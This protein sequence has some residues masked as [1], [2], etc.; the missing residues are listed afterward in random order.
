MTQ[1][2]TAKI[3]NHEKNHNLSNRK[4]FVNLIN[5]SSKNQIE[6]QIMIK[7]LIK[8]I[9]KTQICSLLLKKFGIF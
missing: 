9:N 3:K 7:I 1:Y 8:K 5:F 4:K 2:A 6:V